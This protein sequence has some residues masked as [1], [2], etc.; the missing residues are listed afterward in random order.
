MTETNPNRKSKGSPHFK[1]T[2]FWPILTRKIEP[3]MIIT[4]EELEKG[5][6]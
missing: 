3:E 5:N 6:E 4:D 1:T 2:A